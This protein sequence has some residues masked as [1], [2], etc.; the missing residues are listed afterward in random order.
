M[1]KFTKRRG[2]LLGV[3]LLLAGGGAALAYWTAGGSG[4][5]SGTAAGAQTPLVAN[6][7]TTLAAMYPGDSAQTISGNFDNANSGPIHVS[8]VTA[9]IAS[10]TKA[11]GAPAGTCDAS[12]FTLANATMTVNAEVPAGS[13]QGSFTGTTIKFNNKPTSQDACKGATVNLA[14]AIA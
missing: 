13:G 10:V 9:S 3:V 1:L 8:T 7:T 14:Y 4:T 6:Q 2:L 12:D 11:T 5:G